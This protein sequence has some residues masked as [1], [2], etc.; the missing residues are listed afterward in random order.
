MSVESKK[1]KIFPCVSRSY[2]G[3]ENN[4]EVD[5]KAKLMSEENITN[6]IKSITD[7]KS[8]VIRYD[9]VA[10]KIIFVLNGY[11]VELETTLG[12]SQY[13]VLNYQPSTNGHT[14]IE[15]DLG[16]GSNSSF[17]GISIVTQKPTSGEY[18]W[19]SNYGVVP[20]ESYIKF[21]TKSVSFDFGELK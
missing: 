8:Y 15:G 5:I 2:T 17:H 16:Q 11:Y 14:L 3:D 4:P 1:I 19:I 6:I 18:L 9:D 21:D 13:A 7:R 20:E 12:G 10:K